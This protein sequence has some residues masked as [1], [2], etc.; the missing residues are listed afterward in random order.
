MWFFVF[1]F[2]LPLT[3][4]YLGL[5]VAAALYLLMG[6][7]QLTLPGNRFSTRTGGSAWV[8]IFVSLGAMSA[9]SWAYFRYIWFW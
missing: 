6:V 2:F 5:M 4:L 1:L 3:I 8:V 7:K 9:F